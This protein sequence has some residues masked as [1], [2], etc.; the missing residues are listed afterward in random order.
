MRIHVMS[1]L[2]M[3]FDDYTPQLSPD[4]FDV[5]VL[6]GDIGP[7][8]HA[9]KW[10]DT[11]YPHKDRV[12]IPGNHEYYGKDYIKSDN[13]PDMRYI[14]IDGIHFV[15]ATL[16]TDFK[17][18]VADQSE[19]MR[20]F[21]RGMADPQY[22][23][24]D[25]ARFNAGNAL[26]LHKL[27][28]AFILNHLE[29]IADPEKTVVI[30]H[31]APHGRSITPYWAKEGGSMNASFTSNVLD[32]IKKEIRPKLWIHGHMHS[33]LDY[34]VGATRVVCNP[35]GYSPMAVNPYFNPSLV[36]TI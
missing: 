22:I 14:K 33:S 18:R 1:D 12:I 10:A 17:Y 34:S 5:L 36:I 13:V 3:E 20:A 2:H 24:Y 28:R 30:T 23:R 19:G 32:H 4:A 26:R 15:C 31:H 16:W 25:G 35:R 27:H 6:A 21:E 11:F 29:E 9:A 8:G 7:M